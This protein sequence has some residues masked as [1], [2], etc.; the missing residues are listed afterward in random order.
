MTIS[1]LAIGPPRAPTQRRP[2]HAIV[3]LHGE[4][5][6]D[7]TAALRERLLAALHRSPRLLIVDLS[8]VSFCDAS[9][10]AMLVGTQRR[11][12]A[13]GITLR[14]TA[15]GP[16]ITKLLHITGLDRSLTVHP[17]LHDA[18]TSPDSRPSSVSA[19]Q[20]GTRTAA[21]G[22]RP[23]EVLNPSPGQGRRP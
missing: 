19:V 3:A 18:L 9:G 20:P 13:L 6:L 2:E 5:D 4:L 22:R 23:W 16:L 12:T 11:A 7:T 14:L 8:D 15:P 10:L 17:T 1:A 21:T